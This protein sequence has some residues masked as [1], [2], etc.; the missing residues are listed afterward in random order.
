M[1][2][3]PEITHRKTEQKV[4]LTQLI[5]GLAAIEARHIEIS[6][7]LRVSTGLATQEVEIIKAMSPCL[8][9]IIRIVPPFYL[10]R[11]DVHRRSLRL[12]KLFSF[13]SWA[14]I[15]SEASERAWEDT[16]RMVSRISVSESPLIRQMMQSRQAFLETMSKEL[17][18]LLRQGDSHWANEIG[19]NHIR[20]L[21][22]GRGP[23]AEGAEE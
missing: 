23:A 2:S 1:A 20:D 11:M 3:N 4:D 15:E 19:L 13:R 22:A 21:I 17:Q 14:S 5:L 18:R 8:Q 16:M 7:I 9:E 12:A 10:Q 6:Q